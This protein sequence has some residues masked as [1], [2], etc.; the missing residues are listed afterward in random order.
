MNQPLTD[1]G[2]AQIS[3]ALYAGKKI[4]AIKMY[5]EATGA[6]LTEAKDAVE[7][8]ERTLRE[9]EPEK[10]TAP[11]SKGG[12]LAIVIVLFVPAAVLAFVR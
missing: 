3:S 9:T 8:I 4:A 10:F 11:A 5:R 1:A 7:L 2:L 12:C 6:G